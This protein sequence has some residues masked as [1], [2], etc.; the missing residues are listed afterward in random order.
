[1]EFDFGSQDKSK[2]FFFHFAESIYTMLEKG[3]KKR[4]VFEILTLNIHQSF[5][6]KDPQKYIYLLI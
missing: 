6:Y 4:G 1:M 3:G 2:F 5:T